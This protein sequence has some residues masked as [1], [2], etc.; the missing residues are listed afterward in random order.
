MPLS[1]SASIL[2]GS[3]LLLAL[4]SFVVFLASDTNGNA[5]DST[6]VAFIGNS[7]TF[8][9]DL[10]RVIEAMSEGKI[11]RQDSCLH[12]AL[13][14]TSLLQKGNGMYT[15]WGN[16]THVDDDF[17]DFGACTVRQLLLGYDEE[18]VNNYED[19]YTDDGLNPCFQD[20]D[21]LKYSI[22]IRSPEENENNDDELDGGLSAS[23]SS[24]R[25][26]YAVIND[27]S[28]YPAVY[29]KRMKSASTLWEEYGPMLNATES[30]PILYQTWAYWREDINMTGFVDIPTFTSAL[31]EGY[32]YYAAIL[33]EVLPNHLKPEIAPVGLG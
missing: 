33:E 3:V 32:E 11:Q 5:D 23:S 4:S 18:L 12:G 19:Y 21:Y 24:L 7:F 29:K 8:V 16:S 31:K 22:A 30:K 1:I 10:P 9:N 20:P 6:S 17:P 13:T 25:W 14:V 27:Q 26:D 15:H 2:T 28:M